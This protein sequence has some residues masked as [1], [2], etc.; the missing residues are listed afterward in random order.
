[1]N[2]W[3]QYK[4]GFSK[5]R[6]VAIECTQSNSSFH[7]FAQV[8]NSPLRKT[9]SVEYAPFAT[10]PTATPQWP[11][12][13]TTSA[14]PL[15]IH[16]L[17]LEEELIGNTDRYEMQSISSYASGE[18]SEDTDATDDN[19][20]DMSNSDYHISDNMII[21]RSV[22]EPSILIGWRVNVKDYGPGIIL[23]LK[24]KKFAA[25]KFTIQFENGTIRNIALKRSEKKGREQF[26]LLS[27]LN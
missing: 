15:Q 25:T 18:E 5:L 2:R 20:S 12:A 21:R 8:I 13:T 9:N 27:K 3:Y 1:M 6:F 7:L 4:T 10:P 11:L 24:K 17:D 22:A 19:K 26:T 14:E 23:D 16:G